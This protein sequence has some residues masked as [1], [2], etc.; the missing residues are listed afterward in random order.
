[1][2]LETGD[3]KLRLPKAAPWTLDIKTGEAVIQ[4]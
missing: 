3:G 4:K 2:T 1:M